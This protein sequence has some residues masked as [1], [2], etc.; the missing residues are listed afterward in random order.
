MQSGC[1]K[2]HGPAVAVDCPRCGRG[3]LVYPAWQGVPAGAACAACV[4]KVNAA[5]EFAVVFAGGQWG[6]A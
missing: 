4:A 2:V 3:P 1:G 6:A 5:R